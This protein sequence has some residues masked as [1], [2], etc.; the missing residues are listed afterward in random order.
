MQ[1]VLACPLSADKSLVFKFRGVKVIFALTSFIIDR[2]FL[3]TG[4]SE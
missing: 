1:N 2:V 4:L 3:S